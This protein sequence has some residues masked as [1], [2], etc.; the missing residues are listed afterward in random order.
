[1]TDKRNI[2]NLVLKTVALAM[3]VVT[4]VLAIL[5]KSNP[6]MNILTGIGLFCLSLAALSK[7]DP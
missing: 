6:G 5:Q 1:M 4:I 7:E 3:G 2:V